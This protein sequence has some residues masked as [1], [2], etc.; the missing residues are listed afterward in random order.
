MTVV[1]SR[2]HKSVRMRVRFLVRGPKRMWL[3]LEHDH[4]VYRPTI[5]THGISTP[6]M[7]TLMMRDR[8]E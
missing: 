2:Y 4:P 3:S 8:G 7:N 1:W 6:M 5:K